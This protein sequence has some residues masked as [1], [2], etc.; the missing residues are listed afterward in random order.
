MPYATDPV[1]GL[2]VWQGDTLPVVGRQS[3]RD[4]LSTHTAQIADIQDEIVALQV[5]GSEEIALK[6]IGDDSIASPATNLS[7]LTTGIRNIAIGDG[8]L[9]ALATGESNI[10]IGCESSQTTTGS[11]YNI[12]V[13]DSAFP[14]CPAG[15]GNVILGHNAAESLSTTTNTNV[16]I[17]YGAVVGGGSC[18]NGV[19]IGANA[20]RG[21]TAEINEIV[22]GA[23]ASGNGTNT[24]VIG[25][26]S[27]TSAIIYGAKLIIPLVV[28]DETSN[29]T[30]GTSKLTFRM[31]FAMRITEARAS[32][33]TAPVGPAIIIDVNHNGTSIFSSR[34]HI[35]AT[36]KTS[37]TSLSASDFSTTDL[38]DDAEITID[39]DQ[40]GTST[41]GK[42]LKVCLI[43]IPN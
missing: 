31:P 20:S 34:I 29:L 41:P 17:G 37:V 19:Y 6:D 30:A 33:N 7:A 2:P 22:I 5:Q 32:V 10:S 3:I 43:G 39:I 36:Q 11:S 27:T 8:A 16:I 35:D 9:N 21:D 38:L 13:G 14:I 26:N 18:T 12:V 25:N 23:N 15:S 28:G 42:G 24:T 4:T 1:S 40:V